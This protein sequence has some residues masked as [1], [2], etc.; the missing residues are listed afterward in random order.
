MIVLRQ[1][2]SAYPGEYMKY[3]KMLSAL[4]LTASA[5]A[6][7]PSR[8]LSQGMEAVPARA[9]GEGEGPYPVLVIRGATLVNGTGAPPMGPVDITI[10]GNRI[11]AI[12]AAGTPGLPLSPEREPRGATREIDAA[13]MTVLPGFVDVHGHNG[14]PQKAP[15]ATYGYKLWLAHGVTSVMGVPFYFGDRRAIDEAARSAGN[16]I[17]APRLF[18]YAVIG[19][20]WDGGE[21]DTPDQARAS[22]QNSSIRNRP[23]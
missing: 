13:G 1:V 9:P 8:A 16:R 11:A 10:K 19:D 21:I 20:L 2:H 18:P 6:L 4:A 3:L 17:T 23:P 15:N 12:D 14:D 5:A 7:N 22:A